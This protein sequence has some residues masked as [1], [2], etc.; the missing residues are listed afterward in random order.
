MRRWPPG[1]RIPDASVLLVV[2]VLG[3]RGG[4]RG[5]RARSRRRWRR[6]AGAADL[7][8]RVCRIA[9]E[10]GDEEVVGPGIELESPWP[11]AE[12]RGEAAVGRIGPIS[13]PASRPGVAA[14]PSKDLGH[15]GGGT[16]ARHVARQRVACHRN[17]VERAR[18]GFRRA[19]FSVRTCGGMQYA[20]AD[21]EDKI[22][23]D[24]SCRRRDPK[25]SSVSTFSM[26]TG[27]RTR[28]SG[29]NRVYRATCIAARSCA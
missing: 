7:D 29:A 8:D 16:E 17:S 26:S 14:V 9:A 10:R 21:D 22:Y 11:D 23:Q 1:H 24:A 19:E 25:A 2:V 20:R 18:R 5:G 27:C 12:S 13:N 6:E 4:D 3:G 15:R 28:L